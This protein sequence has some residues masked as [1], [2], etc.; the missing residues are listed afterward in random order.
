MCTH[1]VVTKG[2]KLMADTYIK[3]NDHS[4]SSAFKDHYIVPDYQR[5]YVWTDEQVEQLMAD[6]LDAYNTDNKK[7]YFLGTIVTY[8]SGSQFELIDGQQRLTTFFV[9]LCAIKKI[10]VNCGEQTSVIENLIYSPTMNSEGDVINLYHLQLQYEDAGNCLEL[11]EKGQERPNYLTQS[12][13]RLF[14][15]FKT[16]QDFLSERFPDIAS[17]KKFVVFLLNKT[18]FIRIETYD[19]SDALKIFETINQR[20]KGLDPMDLLKN[21]VFRQ[22][23]RSKFKELNMNW[24]SITRSLEKID[25][26]P[27]RFLRYFIMA[28]YDTSS[29]KD[30]ILREDQIYTWLSNNNAQCHYEEAP[31]QFVQK[32]AQNVELYVKCRMPDD[33]SEG[34]VHLKNIPLLA[35]KSYKL[36]LMLL[37]AA[38]N[39][40]P[41]ALAR[42]KAILESVVYYTVIDK[43]ATNVTERTFAS[44][45][46]D[47]RNIVTIEDLDRFLKD[48]LI[49]T[50]NDWKLDN[51]S[52]FLRL[53][54]NSM[55]QYRIKFIL[56]KIT[57]YVDALR[58]GKTTVDDLTSYTQ[59]AVEIEHIMPQTCADKELY[60]MKDEDFSVYI[61]RLGNLTLLENSINKSIHN[62][63]YAN[64]SKAY[65]QSKFYLTSSLSELVNQGHDTAINR[66]N[67]LLFAWPDWNKRSIE[68]RQEM[69]YRLSEMIWE[70]S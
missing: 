49:P 66:T 39:M 4:I 55:Q 67:S 70:M 43:I 33:K 64:N 61:N 40:N 59:T 62:D 45:C 16:I 5:E 24:K 58:L 47:I 52:N 12:G 57:A 65:K 42:F 7:A 51:K 10:Y 31:F 63:V 28:N 46:K 2:M 44:W 23:D 1:F 6:L 13:E 25:E 29:E 50:V 22:V 37:L 38:S 69:L 26:K 20:G 14:D 17:L 53:G 21:M 54:L 35:G 36:H 60:G 19:I 56:G 18:S 3:Y 9:L 68:E 41:D 30:G 32:M 8:D 27:L 48:T 11:I 34:N 15:A